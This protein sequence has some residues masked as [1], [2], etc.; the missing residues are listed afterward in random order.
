MICEDAIDLCSLD[1][2]VKHL[3]SHL[4]DNGAAFFELRELCIVVKVS[5]GIPMHVYTHRVRWRCVWFYI[6]TESGK[7]PTYLPALEEYCKD[8]DF[9][10]NFYSIHT[11]VHVHVCIQQ[12]DINM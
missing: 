1:G 11:C 4:S 10:G 8:E 2:H 3:W 5:T 9:I 12:Q 6:N 7:V